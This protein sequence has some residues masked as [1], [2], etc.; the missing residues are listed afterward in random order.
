MGRS[1]GSRTLFA[2]CGGSLLLLAGLA[3]VQYRWSARVAAADAQREQEHLNTSA[4]L[5]A[6]DFNNAL[7]QTLEFLQNGARAALQSGEPL[8]AVPKVIGELYYL[9]TPP[10]GPPQVRKLEANGLFET[11]AQPKWISIPHCA[12]LAIAEPPALVIPL[13]DI[14]TTTENRGPTPERVMKMVSRRPDH[15]F[16][17]RI[18]TAYLRT[19]MIPQLISRS[20]GA[21]SVADYDFAVVPRSGSQEPLYGTPVHADLKRP[22]FSIGPGQLAFTRLPGATGQPPGRS[23]VFIQ[24][25]E[26]FVT[27][28]PAQVV[29]LFGPGIWDLE[30]AHKGMPLAA[31]FER[32]RWRDLFLSISV[33]CLLLAAI[34]FLV[35][36]SRRMQRLA[37][38]KMRFIA[39]VSHELRTPVSAIAMLSRNQADGLVTGPEKV[40]QYGELIHQQSRRLNEMVEQTLQY[41]GIH[42]GLPRR[43]SNEIDLRALID[44][45]VAGRREELTRGGFEVEIA[46]SPDLPPVSGDAS[47]LRTAFD[48]LLSNAQ[49]YAEAGH[50]IRISARYS[51]PEK[52]V[53]ISVE[54]RGN[55][56]DPADRAEIFEPFCRGRAAVEAQIPGSGLGLSLVRSAAEAHRGSVTLV[57]EP[58]RGSSF[59]MHLPV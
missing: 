50:W 4:G 35:M 20:F 25:V 59:T 45:A 33:E 58:G 52:E 12:M 49:K 19:T 56:I 54:D 8:T 34:I 37:D 40:K 22:F 23:A 21:T 10:D 46:V 32:A 24:H 13:F 47:L 2:I 16:V 48:N 9:G 44:E 38:Q 28:G 53:Q 17:A 30:V 42:S 6:S 7:G 1:P 31:A 39:G 29:D 3:V 11:A 27:E 5:F 57:S 55:G 36:A 26:S 18:D 41:A 15:C 51:E 14:T 43:T